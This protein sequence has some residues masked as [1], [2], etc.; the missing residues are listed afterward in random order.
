MNK[1]GLSR[2]HDSDTT[3]SFSL[4]FLDG[5]GPRRL[6]EL[7]VAELAEL[8][9]DNLRDFGG[10][11]G[12]P[13]WVGLPGIDPKLLLGAVGCVGDSPADASVKRNSTHRREKD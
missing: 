2:R 8:S 10:A 3:L 1:E 9:D 12:C 5:G 11:V 7:A 13:G 4:P 6:G